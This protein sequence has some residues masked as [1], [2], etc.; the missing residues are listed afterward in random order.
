MPL[1]RPGNT[2]RERR[3]LPAVCSAQ[4]VSL[5]LHATLVTIDSRREGYVAGDPLFTRS[6]QLC[7]NCSLSPRQARLFFISVAA[8]ALLFATLFARQG[9]WPVLPFA[10]LELAVLGWALWVTLLRRHLRQTLTIT[11]GEVSVITRDAAGERQMVFSRHWAR[12]T[13][14]GPRGW[15]P[16]RLYVE[17]HGRSCEVGGFL[18]NAQRQAVF[19]RLARLIGPGGSSPPLTATDGAAESGY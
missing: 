9:F 6:I 14:R 17:S 15:L 19:V 10:G 11:D 7:P 4:A 5:L 13:L 2:S 1:H 8:P 18:T 16:S 12:V 3:G